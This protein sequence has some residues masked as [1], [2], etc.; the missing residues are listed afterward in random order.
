MTAVSRDAAKA[1][2]SGLAADHFVRW[3]A[4]ETSQP[5]VEALRG[6]DAVVHLLGETVNPG[7]GG[8]WTDAKKSSIMSSRVLSTRNLVQAMKTLDQ[9]DRP[10]ALV[11]GSAI[12]WYGERG[13]DEVRA[14]VLRF[15]P[16]GLRLPCCLD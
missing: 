10:S 1:K 2:A 12:G 13:D 8:R 9:T 14:A 7:F 16:R 15:A 11:C 3:E 6:A 5:P 4:P